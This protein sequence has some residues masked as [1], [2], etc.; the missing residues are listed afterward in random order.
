MFSK[1]SLIRILDVPA[2]REEELDYLIDN[3][4]KVLSKT[5]SSCVIV[6]NGRHINIFPGE[7]ELVYEI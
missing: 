1:D 6:V 3:V 5:S 4:Y 2:I 7:A